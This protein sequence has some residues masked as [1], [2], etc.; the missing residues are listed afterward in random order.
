MTQR[1]W[2]FPETV[3]GGLAH[4]VA[5]GARLASGRPKSGGMIDR[6]IDLDKGLRIIRDAYLGGGGRGRGGGLG[7]GRGAHGAADGGSLP[8]TAV[9]DTRALAGATAGAAAAMVKADI[10]RV[11]KEVL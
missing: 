1:A 2:N 5:P 9:R 4:R 10:L 7:G 8:R 3:S 6:G 11:N